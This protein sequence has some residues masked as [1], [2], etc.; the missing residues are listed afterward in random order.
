MPAA[1]Q[2]ILIVDDN[3]E[4]LDVIRLMLERH[5]FKVSTKRNSRVGDFIGEVKN[6]QPDLVLLD[7]SLGWADGCDLCMIIKTDKALRHIPVVMFSAYHKIK[8]DCFFAGA[9][10]FLQKPFEMPELLSIIH[11]LTLPHETK[12]I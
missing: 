12:T 2:H 5:A 9:D 1:N 3:Q 4:I 10:A 7:K 6:I 11:S 8:D